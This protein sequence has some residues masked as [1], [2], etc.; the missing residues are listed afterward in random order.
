[1]GV[2]VLL[3]CVLVLLLA[4]NL[5]VPS[6]A[7]QVSSLGSSPNTQLTSSEPPLGLGGGPTS[8]GESV[9]WENPEISKI[10][11]DDATGAMLTAD[12]RLYMWGTLRMEHE[13][14]TWRNVP[15]EVYLTSGVTPVDVL[16]SEEN[17]VLLSED[18]ELLFT[19]R[20]YPSK[21]KGTLIASIHQQRH[22]A[23]PGPDAANTVHCEPPY[24]GFV[25]DMVQERSGRLCAISGSDDT[26][27]TSPAAPRVDGSALDAVV[28]LGSQEAGRRAVSNDYCEPPQ[29]P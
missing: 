16:V 11:I 8:G 17:A 28:M 18:S 13:P 27:T 14:T 2:L 4:G 29:C 15:V 19:H 24:I 20:E 6:N 25:G 21:G 1:M 26:A 9:V 12:G 3:A 5:A 23:I 7:S 10:A 22:G